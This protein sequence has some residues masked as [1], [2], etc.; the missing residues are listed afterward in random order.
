MGTGVPNLGAFSDFDESEQEFC[1]CEM[2]SEPF[3]L[4]LILLVAW[5]TLGA[6]S[7]VGQPLHPLYIVVVAVTTL[8]TG[9]L[10]PPFE[11]LLGELLFRL[12]EDSRLVASD[13]TAASPFTILLGVVVLMGLS[14]AEGVGAAA[15]LLVVLLVELTTFSAGV[16][17][18][19]TA[20]VVEMTAAEDTS[21]PFA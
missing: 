10:G 17:S 7:A 21:I 5:S 20:V 9:A 8:V 11:V 19:L 1:P 6:M 3:S 15:V 14:P 2:E 4:P 18:L 16:A 13:R 12:S